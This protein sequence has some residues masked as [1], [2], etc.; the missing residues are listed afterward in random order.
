M[1]N[2]GFGKRFAAILI[3]TI[4]VG[5]PMYIVNILIFGYSDMIN[6]NASSY[7]QS[8]LLSMVVG[9]SYYIGMWTYSNGATIGKKILKIKIVK[10][11]G[12]PVT[13]GTA[14]GRYFGYILSGI[15]FG[16]GFFWV[17]WDK[18]K[19]GWHDKISNT[20]VVES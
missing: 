14:F 9:L 20:K 1:E 19:R 12:S 10:Y 6:P 8:Q 18:E 16:L 4:I 11:D 5:I 2:I 3:D 13:I 17:I 7:W 15:I